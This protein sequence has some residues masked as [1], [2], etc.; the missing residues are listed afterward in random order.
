MVTGS[1]VGD[2]LTVSR[3]K[4]A[5]CHQDGQSERGVV[6]HCERERES[7]SQRLS[8]NFRAGCTV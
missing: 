7:Q 8:L 1:G 6:V 3:H 4:A 2:E 5:N